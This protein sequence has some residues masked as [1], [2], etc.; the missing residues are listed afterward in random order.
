MQFKKQVNSELNEDSDRKGELT[1]P[2]LKTILIEMRLWEQE[3]F[4]QS[5]L[6]LGAG[7]T[8]QGYSPKC[9]DE[10]VEAVEADDISVLDT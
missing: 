10:V 3:E 9:V 1:L 7:D 4:H 6:P 8:R 5:E 2:K